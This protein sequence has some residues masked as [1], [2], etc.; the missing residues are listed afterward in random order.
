[1]NEKNRD[2]VVGDALI[3]EMR[4]PEGTERLAARSLITKVGDED[5][6]LLYGTAPEELR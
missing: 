4:N 2:V 6:E 3:D 5:A 1:M